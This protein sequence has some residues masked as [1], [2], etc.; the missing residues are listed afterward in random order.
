MEEFI[1]LLEIRTK[2]VCIKF[3]WKTLSVVVIAG[4][5]MYLDLP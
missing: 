2:T 3:S 5:C 1:V 4:L